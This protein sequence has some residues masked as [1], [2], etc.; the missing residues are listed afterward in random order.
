M[1]LDVFS[2]YHPSSAWPF[3]SRSELALSKQ[4][5]CLK[6][7]SAVKKLVTTYQSIDYDVSLEY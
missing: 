7:V 3:G 4:R 5:Y 1:S 2:P 6:L